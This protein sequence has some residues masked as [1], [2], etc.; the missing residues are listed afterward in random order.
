MATIS[1]SSSSSSSSEHIK[2]HNSN[3]SSI[4]AYAE[5][6]GASTIPSNYH[7]LKEQHDDTNHDDELAA[8]IPII[9]FS[10]LTSDDP[11]IHSKVVH[12]LAEA[13]AQWGF[14]M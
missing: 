9:D 8:S 1:S 2:L 10:L 11:Q 5:S 6:N 7:S 14:F 4:K 3:I 13:C 12:Q